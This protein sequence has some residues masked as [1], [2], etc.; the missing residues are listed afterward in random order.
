VR[1]VQ[2]GQG[3]GGPQFRVLHARKGGR[4]HRT[5][6]SE[7]QHTGAE[8]RTSTLAVGTGQ[9]ALGRS[10]GHWAKVRVE[11]YAHRSVR[12]KWALRLGTSVE[13]GGA[14]AEAEGRGH[15]G[16]RGGRRGGLESGYC[17]PQEVTRNGDSETGQ[18]ELT[19]VS[20]ASSSTFPNRTVQRLRPKEGCLSRAGWSEGGPCA[21]D[22]GV[23]ESGREDA[24]RSVDAVGAAGA[25]GTSRDRCSCRWR[26]GALLEL[27]SPALTAP[28]AAAPAS[29]AGADQQLPARK[30]A[31]KETL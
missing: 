1:Q 15:R 14:V 4:T 20:S 5:E 26:Q 17:M 30:K 27:L 19:N 8:S 16:Q 6:G 28:F 25:G 22:H 10:E 21:A 2:G 24:G 3:G 11:G 13:G 18:M 31:G 9:W 29:F 12:R 7:Q 23:R